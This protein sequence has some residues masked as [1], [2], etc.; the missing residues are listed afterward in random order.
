[1]PERRISYLLSTTINLLSKGEWEEDRVRTLSFK[2]GFSGNYRVK[3]TPDKFRTFCEIDWSDFGIGLLL[4]GSLEKVLLSRVFEVVIVDTEHPDQ[5]P[6]IDCW[7]DAV[8]IQP[9]WLKSCLEKACKVMV[10]RVTAAFKCR[11]KK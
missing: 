2:R 7:Q 4:E 9:M 11:E 8:L 10:A 5:F 6:Y 3:L 1:V